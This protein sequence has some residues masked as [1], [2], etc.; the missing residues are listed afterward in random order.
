MCVRGGGIF[1]KKQTSFGAR[2]GSKSHLVLGLPKEPP[3]ERWEY[4]VG[5]EA[6]YVSCRD[7]RDIFC[8]LSLDSCTFFL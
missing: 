7:S 8:L 5:L 4:Q 6:A 2:C 3:L 1:H